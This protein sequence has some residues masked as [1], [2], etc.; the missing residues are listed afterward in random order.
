[1]YVIIN[2]VGLLIESARDHQV[3][4]SRNNISSL[5]WADPLA[6]TDQA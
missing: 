2:L 5:I 3:V 1:M 6:G 4:Q